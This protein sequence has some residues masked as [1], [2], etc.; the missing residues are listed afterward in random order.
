MIPAETLAA[1]EAAYRQA[2]YRVEL[3]GGELVLKVG[4]HDAT[5]D[6]RLRE[7]AGVQSHW[8]IVTPC[9]PDSRRLPDEDNA[10][11]LA[12]LAAMVADRHLRGVGSVNRDPAGQW[13]DEPGV[14]LCDPPPGCAEELGRHFRQN[15]I[16][17]AALGEAPRLV[18]L[19]D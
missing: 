13:P 11:R 17:A 18:W 10:R 12:R 7:E 1:W 15:A 8:A 4:A 5:G 3:P 14:L 6:R 9:N 16:L 19:I 2:E